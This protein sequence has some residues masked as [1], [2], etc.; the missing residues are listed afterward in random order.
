MGCGCDCG[1]IMSRPAIAPVSPLEIVAAGDIIAG[2]DAAV[3]VD[4]AGAVSVLPDVSGNGFNLSQAVAANQPTVVVGG[5]PNGNDSIL[6]DGVDDNIVNTVLDLPPPGTTPLTFWGVYRQVTWG[7]VQRHWSVGAGANSLAVR[8]PAAGVSPELIQYAGSLVNVN[9][10][11]TVNTYMIQEVLFN[12]TAGDF[13][14]VGGVRATGANAGNV[15]PSAGFT[16]GANGALTNFGNIEFVEG[17]LF[18]AALTIQ[19]RSQLRSYATN[20]YGP[21]P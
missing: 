6:F 7:L 14:D 13:L 5:G 1:S 17:W 21:I 8:P 3:R 16:L 2:W 18:G 12:N 20:R 19:Q 10:A 11:M 15:D 4:T 9:A